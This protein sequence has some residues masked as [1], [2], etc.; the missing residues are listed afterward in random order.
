MKTPIKTPPG[1][2]RI[3]GPKGRMVYSPN[4]EVRSQHARFLEGIGVIE[5]PNQ[6][7]VVQKHLKNRFFLKLDI[8]DA[9]GSVTQEKVEK[10]LDISF[11]KWAPYFFHKN[12]GLIQGAPASSALFYLSCGPMDAAMENACT[13]LGLTYSRY[14]DDILISSK[15]RLRENT[16]KMVRGVIRS[17]GF[18]VKEKK[19]ALVDN[20]YQE[21]VFVG[22]RI[23]NGRTY[24]THEF[25]Q[26]L[27]FT[28]PGS[29]QQ[30]GMLT[31]QMGVLALESK[32]C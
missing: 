1:F 8:Q 7:D 29:A 17:V 11:E 15:Q 27:L 28:Q 20:K 3:L 4:E 30:K 5:Y 18:T 12:G 10:I 23:V 13:M 19:S 26:K 16:R 31:W 2:T 24:T 6:F 22:V 21:I 32:D 14:C 25:N 9:F